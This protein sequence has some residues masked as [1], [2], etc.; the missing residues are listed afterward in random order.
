MA[1]SQAVGNMEQ[2]EPQLLTCEKEL[3]IVSQYSSN[4]TLLHAEY[5]QGTVP[6]YIYVPLNLYVHFYLYVNPMRQG[7]C[8]C[9]HFRNDVVKV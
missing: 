6:L 5:V 9:S 4:R 1:T 8:Y 3:K 2:R 7:Y